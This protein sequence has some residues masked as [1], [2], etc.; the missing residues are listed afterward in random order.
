MGKSL[1]S[2]IAQLVEHR[3]VN[4]NGVVVE[5]EGLVH[6][7]LVINKDGLA[8]SSVRL[9]IPEIVAMERANPFL[10]E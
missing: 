2:L 1:Y 9:T 4:I 6:A 10:K 7:F 5:G 3:T 8:F